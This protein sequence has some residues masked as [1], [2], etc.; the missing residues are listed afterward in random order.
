[1]KQKELLAGR[2]DQSRF[3]KGGFVLFGKYVGEMAK[4]FPERFAGKD[5]QEF[6]SG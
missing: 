6:R 3:Q 5:G 1:M 2:S 4:V